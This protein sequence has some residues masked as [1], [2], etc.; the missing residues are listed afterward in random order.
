MGMKN[1]AVTGRDGMEVLR[2]WVE[3]KPKLDGDRR[4]QKYSLP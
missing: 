4:G 3:I 1:F 2:G